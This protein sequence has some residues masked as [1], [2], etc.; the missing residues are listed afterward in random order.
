MKKTF[1]N[2]LQSDIFAFNM[3]MNGVKIVHGRENGT[4]YVEV[5]K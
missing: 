5:C 1:T 4:Y 3:I 2:K